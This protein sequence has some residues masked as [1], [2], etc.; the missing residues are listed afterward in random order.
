MK[1]FILKTVAVISAF[2]IGV[3]IN[4][5]CGKSERYETTPSSTQ[6]LW[7][8]VRSLTAEIT[9]LKEDVSQLQSEIETLKTTG[10][11]N[12]EFL[13]DGLYFNRA[14]IVTS[15]PKIMKGISSFGETIHTYTYTYDN[16]GRM[17]RYQTVGLDVKYE[18]SGKT[19]TATTVSSAND[20]STTSVSKTEYY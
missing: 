7:N 11:N 17:S 19:V 20:I 12:G 6:E 1:R 18:Y 8:S 2:F 4:N 5:S 13:V 14:G 9:Q 10:D 16:Q 15:K 3:F